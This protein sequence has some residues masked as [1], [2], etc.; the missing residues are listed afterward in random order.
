MPFLYS[1]LHKYSVDGNYVHLMEIAVLIFVHNSG[2]NNVL[3][4]K[5]ACVH[6]CTFHNNVCL[7]ECCAAVV[8]GEGGETR[9]GYLVAFSAAFCSADAKRLSVF[10]AEE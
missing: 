6:L 8:N 1:V 9:F 10:L 4:A 2:I 3:L 7:S 5:E